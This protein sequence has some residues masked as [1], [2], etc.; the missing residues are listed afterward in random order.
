MEI[1]S[2]GDRDL[3]IFDVARGVPMRLAAGFPDDT[4]PVWSTDGRSIAYSS[5]VAG[6]P[7]IYIREADGSGQPSYVGPVGGYAAY[8][9]DWSRDGTL[10]AYET[11]TR[12][13]DTRLL[14]IDGKGTSRTFL[15]GPGDQIDARF[16]PDGRWVVFVSSE[17]GAHDVF[18]APLADGNVRHRVSA[19]GGANPVW[20][21]DGRQ[22]YYTVDS[23][24]YAASFS[25]ETA[26]IGEARELFSLGDNLEIN[27]LDITPDG[28]RFL[29]GVIDREKNRA[30]ITVVL[31]WD[32][33]L[34]R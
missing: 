4:S 34:E 25:G 7:A 1:L 32:G 6:A 18:V 31:D 10:I 30:R 14:P 9:S 17:L 12:S 27:R 20:S 13:E 16:S 5:D 28:E 15:E 8:P 26:A 2:I 33:L 3:W 21:P 11:T 22:L 24:V 23:T 29:A 19:A